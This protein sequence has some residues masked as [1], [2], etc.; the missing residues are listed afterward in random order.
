MPLFS[1]RKGLTPLR[2]A[3]Q[4]DDVDMPLRNRLWSALHFGLWRHW[5]P[6]D[7]SGYQS[8]D[9][10]EV[11]RIVDHLWVKYFRQ[12]F[13]TRPRFEPGTKGSAYEQIRRHFF[14]DKWF[15]VYDFIESLVQCVPEELR[16]DLKRSLNEAMEEENSGYRL[17]GTEIVG[18]VDPTECESVE[19]ALLN[20]PPQ[21]G[22]HITRA[23]ELLSDRARPDYRNSV[24]ESISAVESVCQTLAKKSGASLGDCM[25]SIKSLTSMHPAFEKAIKQLYGYTSDEGGIRHALTEDSSLPTFADAK[26]MLVACSALINFLVAKAAEQGR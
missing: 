16:E 18:V 24:K 10:I 26:F 14:E 19:M 15:E 11:E 3:L 6:R 25:A 23:L 13:D 7:L 8:P 12:P 22:Q 2:T 4:V 20:G 1:Q 17:V 9:A 5:S 21:S